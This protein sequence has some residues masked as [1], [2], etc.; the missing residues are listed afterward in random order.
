MTNISPNTSLAAVVSFINTFAK[1]N[2]IN[3]PQIPA[4]TV[5]Q[6]SFEWFSQFNDKLRQAKLNLLHKV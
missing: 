6:Q 1:A 3:A 5:D 2:D 4:P